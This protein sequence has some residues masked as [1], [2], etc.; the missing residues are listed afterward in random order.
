MS[1]LSPPSSPRHRGSRV[2]SPSSAPAV[3]GG[4]G[5][6]AGS[7]RGGGRAE[8]KNAVERFGCLLISAM[9]RRRGV[10]MF[11]P[12]LYISGILMYMGTMGFNGVD[13]S[14]SAVADAVGPGSVYRSPQVFEKL[15]PFMEA[16]SNRSSNMVI[17]GFH[18]S[19]LEYCSLFCGVTVALRVIVN[20]LF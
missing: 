11:A 1:S 5:G 16:E 9:Y 6:G 3:I 19:N 13:K 4:Y 12:L 17:A 2:K 8:L 20:L 18:C 14:R 15:W 10:L 7:F